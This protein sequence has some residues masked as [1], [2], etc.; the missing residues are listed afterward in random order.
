MTIG[1]DATMQAILSFYPGAQRA[2]FR[3]YHIGGCASCGFAPDEKLATVCRRAGNIDPIEA[4]AWI[5]QCDAQ[6]RANEITPSQLHAAMCNAVTPVR[7]L[8]IRTREEWDV[9]RLE[10]AEFFTQE[11]MQQIL[12][13][14]PREDLIVVYDHMGKRSLDATAYFAGQGFTNV[15]SLRGGIDAW[16]AEID[17]TMPRYEVE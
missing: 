10:G 4:L 16:A 7:I 8:D 2:L 12:S 6:D 11:L 1:P 14:W 13:T 3:K 5:A 9:V 15:K 17:P